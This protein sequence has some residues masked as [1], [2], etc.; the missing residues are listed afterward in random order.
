VLPQ[1]HR[2]YETISARIIEVNHL[3]VAFRPRKLQTVTEL[4]IISFVFA[5]N[6]S[7]DSICMEM[8]YTHNKEVYLQNAISEST[9]LPRQV[10]AGS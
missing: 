6:L 9:I 1:C 5:A 10:P 8:L 3:A 7:G 4:T 2:H